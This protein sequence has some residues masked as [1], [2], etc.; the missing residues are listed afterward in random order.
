MRMA[1]AEVVVMGQV[2]RD[3]VLLVDE[4]PGAGGSAPVRERREMLGGK[5]ANQAVGLAQLGA[6]VA[7]LGVVGDDAAG[8]GLIEQAAADGIDTA[9]VV[10]RTGTGSALIVDIVDRS[11]RWRY[12]EDIPDATLL[13]EADVEAARG[14]L[15]RARFVLLQLQQPPGAALRAARLARDAGIVLDGAPPA[16]DPE[17][18]AAADVLRADA[19]EA[20]LLA[21]TPVDTP[22]TAARL[23]RDLLRRG[24]SLVALAVGDAGNM[25]VWPDGELFLPLE[26]VPVVDTTGAGDAL[27][28]ALTAALLHGASP[29]DAARH[30]VAAAG[31]TTA[32]PGGRP[33]LRT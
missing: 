16:D 30:A 31:A 22:E 21:G 27:V 2:A 32:H 6:R 26:D 9:P 7:L 3:L 17:L 15:R 20:A 11:A 29:P 14:S 28:V 25:F 19:R 33:A 8:T 1:G 5:G 24:P 12:L 13:T 18:L 23:G 10:R 4:V